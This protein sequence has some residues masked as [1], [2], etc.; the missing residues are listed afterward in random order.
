LGATTPEEKAYFNTKIDEINAKIAN[1]N[2][3]YDEEELEE[4]MEL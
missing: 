3:S 4:E 2:V 1:I